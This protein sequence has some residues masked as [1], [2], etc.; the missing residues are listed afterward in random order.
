MITQS[1]NEG[2]GDEGQKVYPLIEDVLGV[3]LPAQGQIRKNLYEAFKRVCNKLGLPSE[4]L[5]TRTQLYLLHAGVTKAQ[6]HHLIEAFLRQ[7][8]LFGAPPT[9]STTLMNRWEDD[10]L[11]YLP[12]TVITLRRA[13]LWDE[14]AWNARLYARIARAPETFQPSTHFEEAFLK[15]YQTVKGASRRSGW[16]TPVIPRPRLHW[17][18]NGLVLRLPRSEGRIPVRFDNEARARRYKGGEDR[19]LEQPWPREITCEIGGMAHHIEFMASPDRVAIFDMTVGNLLTERSVMDKSALDLDSA[20][21]MI[22]ARRPFTIAGEEAMPLGD[23]CWVQRVTLGLRG[24]ELDFGGRRIALR[25]RPRRRL[26]LKGDQIASGKAGRLFG[27][28]ATILVETGLADNEIRKLRLNCN[29]AS[30]LLDVEIREGNAELPLGACNLAG[31]G[32]GADPTH[33]H[34]ELMAPPI[35]NEAPRP[36]GITLDAWIWPGFRLAQGILFHANPAPS[37]FLAEYSSHV[38]LSADGLHLDAQGGYAHASAAFAIDSEMVVFRLPWPDIT[39]QRHRAD[40]TIT[41]VQIGARISLGQEDRLDH[42]SIRC[43]DRDAMLRVG[44]R[45]ETSPFTLG[46]TRNIALSELINQGGDARVVLRRASGAEVLLVEIVDVMQPTRFEIRPWQGGL[47]INLAIGVAIDAMAIEV[48]TEFGERQFH[49]VALGRRPVRHAAPDWL[50]AWLSSQDARQVRLRIAQSDA[51]DG[52]KIGRC[53]LRP[54]SPKPDESWRPGRQF[55][56]AA[57]HRAQSGPCAAGSGQD[58]L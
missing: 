52:L 29:G 36:S 11:E 12:H 47:E 25:T 46:M 40:G 28:E 5:D 48:E 21:A 57:H 32:V 41:P 38:G 58:A 3:K 42:L 17:G 55:C 44:R 6:L 53:F 13:I 30:W 8:D 18:D 16:A 45:V 23:D 35:E 26:S 54:D 14:T 4:G 7:H 2:Y 20:D 24:T 50:H 43:P 37:N 51:R 31:Q 39:L 15:T 33:L 9:E 49:E 56:P 34:V 27:P 19:V 22:A 1:L 10:A